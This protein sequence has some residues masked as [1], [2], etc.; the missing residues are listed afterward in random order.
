ALSP[1][2]N[3]ETGVLACRWLDGK[4][5]RK[6]PEWRSGEPPLISAR[7]RGR[8][9]PDNPNA[10]LGVVAG[11]AG[12]VVDVVEDALLCV[13][14]ALAVSEAEARLVKINGPRVPGEARVPADHSLARAPIPEAP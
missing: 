14:S 8:A 7:R 1:F 4:F 12:A 10:D 13:L 9:R 5:D 11:V 3:C 6:N 2:R